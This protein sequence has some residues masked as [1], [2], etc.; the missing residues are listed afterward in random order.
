MSE[1]IAFVT[2]FSVG[3]SAGLKHFAQPRPR[4]LLGF[5]IASARRRPDMQ[6]MWQKCD[7]NL[8]RGCN[9]VP[10]VLRLL[11]QWNVLS[12]PR[13][14]GREISAKTKNGQECVC[15]GHV[16]KTPWN[17]F[18][19][20]QWAIRVGSKRGSPLL[21]PHLD[22]LWTPSG[23]PSGPPFGPPFFLQKIIVWQMFRT[24]FVEQRGACFSCLPVLILRPLPQSPLVFSHSFPRYYFCSRSTIWMPGTGY[25]AVE[26]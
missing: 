5:N 25:R 14:K 18:R 4:D 26:F 1:K 15:C 12:N 22:P 3:F 13:R 17:S 24:I 20:I 2:S 9:L 8:S 6:I 16:K 19:G 10:R 11:G 23:P 21:D 7:K